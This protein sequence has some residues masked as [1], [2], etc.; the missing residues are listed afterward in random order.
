MTAVR[1][2][3]GRP[4]LRVAATVALLAFALAAGEAAGSGPAGGA[5]AR[6]RGTCH[7]TEVLVAVDYSHFGGPIALGCAPGRLPDA[8]VAMHRAGFLTAGDEADGAGFVCRIGIAGRGVR[9]ERPTPAVDPC[10]DTPP[11]TAYWAF[12]VA[13]AGRNSWSYGA[14]GAAAYR[15]AAGSVEGWS[16]GSGLPPAVTPS[17]LRAALSTPRHVRPAGRPHILL[18]SGIRARPTDE[19]GGTPA[20]LLVAGAIVAGLAAVGATLAVRRRREA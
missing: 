4:L 11:A 7:R 3:A 14:V 5:T 6:G 1:P 18:V 19:S 2:R 13:S 20:S 9:S 10:V 12:W 15:P 17:Q 8:L 16:F